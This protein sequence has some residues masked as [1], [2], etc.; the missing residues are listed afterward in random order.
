VLLVVR[1]GH[2]PKKLL[3]KGL[4]NLDG[5]NLLGIVINDSPIAERNY[6]REYYNRGPQR[7]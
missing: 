7:R 6:Y 2:T 1:Q 4:K 5:M 3:Q